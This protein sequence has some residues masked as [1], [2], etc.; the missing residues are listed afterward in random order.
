MPFFAR[1]AAAPSDNHTHHPQ[2][3]LHSL[4]LAALGIIYGDI[5]TSPLYTIKECF[6][7]SHG[8]EA[9]AANVLGILSLVFWSD[10]KSVV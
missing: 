5:G 6:S 10:R 9:N 1:S 2:A 8:V 7:G 3:P 4:A